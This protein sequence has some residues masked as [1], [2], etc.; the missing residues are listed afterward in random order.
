M[1][2]LLTGK[3]GIGKST[4]LEKIITSFAPPEIS[5]CITQ[6]IR[7]SS[8]DR[9][10]FVSQGIGKNTREICIAHSLDIDSDVCVGKYNIDITA[11]KNTMSFVKKKLTTQL[12]VIDEI[13]RIQSKAAGVIDG[14]YDLFQNNKNHIILSTIVYDDESFARPFKENLSNILLKVSLENR[15]YLIDVL[16]SLIENKKHYSELSINQKKYFNERLSHYVAMNNKTMALK[17]V[18]H[19]LMYVSKSSIISS[20]EDYAI[21]GQSSSHIVQGNSC[22]CDL[23][24]GRGKYL[25]ARQSDCSH[26]QAVELFKKQ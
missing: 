6:E 22:T 14:I 16:L 8:G 4:V 13:G 11:V 15:E 26:I 5:G 25:K 20:K 2:I 10:G 3:P 12:V 21:L 7:D 23:Y 24:R 18:N 19:S 17:I 1:N 9:I